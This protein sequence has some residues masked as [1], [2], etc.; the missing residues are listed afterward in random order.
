MRAR[1]Q[2]SCL[3]IVEPPASLLERELR[4]RVTSGEAA[5]DR[6][7][8]N[9]EEVADWVGELSVKAIDMLGYCAATAPGKAWPFSRDEVGNCLRTALSD[10]SDDQR[11]GPYEHRLAAHVACRLIRHTDRIFGDGI[12]TK[13]DWLSDLGA[14]TFTV[15]WACVVA[16]F[17]AEEMLA[18]VL[19]DGET[20]VASSRYVVRMGPF[21]SVLDQ[22]VD[23][24]TDEI[25]HRIVGQLIDRIEERTPA[26]IDGQED[27]FAAITGPLR[28]TLPEVDQP[29]H[30]HPPRRKPQFQEPPHQE[31]SIEV[32]VQQPVQQEPERPA[33][34]GTAGS[35]VATALH[36]DAPPPVDGNG[37][38]PRWHRAQWW[39]QPVVIASVVAL[40]LGGGAGGTV[41]WWIKPAPDGSATTAPAPPG[42]VPPPSGGEA[43]FAAPTLTHVMLRL[44]AYPDGGVLNDK[45]V[46]V[47][48]HPTQA[49]A[50]MNMSDTLVVEVHL[51]A[52]DVPPDPTETF[53][54][55]LAPSGLLT[56]DPDFK[57]TV[58][59]AGSAPTQL[60]RNLTPAPQPVVPP[61]PP[62]GDVVF[63]VRLAA[64]PQR[65]VINSDGPGYFCGFNTQYVN[66]VLKSD[67]HDDVPVNTT[68]PVSVLR[69]LGCGD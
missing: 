3:V 27:D 21:M 38:R 4:R 14:S 35:G 53:N 2:V 44:Y 37:A 34:D 60:T 24:P 6:P 54:I 26:T 51:S 68:L 33:S 62:S 23:E 10:A 13:A 45:I 29:G 41:A 65:A 48:E 59:V 12:P 15:G 36:N 28:R 11:D 61:L 7:V 18:D 42:S 17:V 63:T 39:K 55:G 46:A 64:K 66:V 31:S 43:A 16:R 69:V 19:D 25:H 30:G 67:Q 9:A 50:V 32:P 52:T 40:F 22:L 47:P 57:N 58:S 49:R 5:Y 8:G 1:G 56:L 20:T